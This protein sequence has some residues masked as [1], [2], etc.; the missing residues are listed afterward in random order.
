MSFKINHQANGLGNYTKDGEFYY[1]Y[2]NVINKGGNV[3]ICGNVSIYENK[4]KRALLFRAKCN[5]PCSQR[6]VIRICVHTNTSHMY[7]H[8]CICE[9]FIEY[10]NKNEENWG[11]YRWGGSD[12]EKEKM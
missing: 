8:I 10:K 2:R 11:Y 1:Y 7:I 9:V 3:L 12:I 5:H 4:Q 6:C